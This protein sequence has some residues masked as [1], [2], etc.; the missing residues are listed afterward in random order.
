MDF[1]KILDVENERKKE[2]HVSEI[3]FIPK[4]NVVAE[5]VEFKVLNIKNEI[6]DTMYYDETIKIRM[7]YDVYDETIKTRFWELL[8]VLVMINILMG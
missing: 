2:E 3:E 8:F 4:N 1:L 6:I 7:V 5:V